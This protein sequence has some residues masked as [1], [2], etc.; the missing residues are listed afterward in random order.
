[1]SKTKALLRTHKSDFALCLGLLLVARL[2]Q[3]NGHGW[4]DDFA[5]YVNQARG[6]TDGT[7]W[8]VVRDNRFALDNSAWNYFSP[9]AYPWGLPVLLSP[10]IAVWGINF[11]LLKLVPT[12][13]Y[14][15][16]TMAT[17]SLAR[18]RFGPLTATAVTVVVALNPWFIS[19]T[20]AVLSDLV[21]LAFALTAVVFV[22]RA[23]E[24]R[25]VFTPGRNALIIASVL[26]AL[27]FHVR[28]DALGLIPAIAATQL[29]MVRSGDRPSRREVARPWCWLLGLAIGIHLIL[30]APILATDAPGGGLSAL[31]HHIIWY[32][33]PFAELVG[34][35]EIGDQPV[36]ALGSNLLGAVIF[37]LIIIGLV[38]ALT[39]AAIEFLR[40]KTSTRIPLATA[41]AGI[42]LLVLLTPYHYQRYIYTSTVLGLILAVDG[43]RT[44]FKALKWP[45]VGLVVACCVIAIPAAQHTDTTRQSIG[46]HV[47]HSYTLWGPESPVALELFEAVVNN[48]DERDVIVF[49]QART[50]NLYTRRCAIQGNNLEMLLSRGDWFAQDRIEDYI[51]TPMTVEEAQALGLRAVWSN[52]RFILWKIP[53]PN[54]NEI[55]P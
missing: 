32:R 12:L 34:L 39:V 20:G 29:M 51:Q 22:D 18:R 19:A 55:T 4:G 15:A 7:L 50:M 38:V 8:S 25:D 37:W 40:R 53:D 31:R 43:L 45:R 23:V 26:I 52:D 9:T 16:A 35:K 48:T 24:I 1:M 30:P 41:F 44:L 54:I 2:S 46:Y 49:N 36:S 27:S 5:L 47:N 21:F 14:I 6:L 28:R 10:I 13:G 11:S 42:S 33:E 17:L 3:E